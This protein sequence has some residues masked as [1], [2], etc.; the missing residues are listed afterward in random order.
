ME[1]TSKRK[2][3]AETHPELA[4]EWHPTKNGDLKPTDV[5]A[6]SDKKVWW[7]LPYD[8]P[9]TGKHFDF[10]WLA[11]IRARA[12][13][14]QQCPYL[15]GQKTWTGFN[16]LATFCPELAKEWHPTKNG[17][18]TPFDVTCKSGKKV[19]WFLPYD[20]P[21]NRKTFCF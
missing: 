21:R 1:N 5:L 3:L 2:S 14:S 19:W 4:R 13:Q 7:F 6:G 10:E 9:K 8:D 18:L 15:L 16:D 20:N 11:R 12:K 17:D